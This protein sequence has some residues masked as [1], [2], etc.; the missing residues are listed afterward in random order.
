MAVRMAPTYALKELINET[1]SPVFMTSA[2][3]SGEVTCNSLEEV[4]KIFPTLDGMME[5]SVSFGEASAI[6]D[7]TSKVIKIQRLG[8]ILEDHIIEVLKN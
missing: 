6:I 7:C 1:G 4:E 8:P 3:R 5:G 2:N